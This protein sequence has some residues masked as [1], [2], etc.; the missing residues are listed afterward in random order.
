M[1]SK[2]A[3]V[4]LLLA[5][6]CLVLG[7]WR[8]WLSPLERIARQAGPPP[9]KVLIV[10]IDGATFRIAD[11]LLAAGRLPVLQGLIARGVRAELRSEK[12][13]MS[14][15]LWTTVITGQERRDHGIHG[16]VVR[17]RADQEGG[18]LVGSRDRKVLA[19]WNIASALSRR[20]GFLGWWASWPAEPVRGFV[21]S[22]RMTEDRWNL[23]TGG[24][25][26]TGLVYPETLAAEVAPLVVRPDELPMGEILELAELTP[27]EQAELQAARRP[28][29]GHALSVLKFAFCSQRSLEKMAL[30]LLPRDQPDLAGLFLVASDPISHT[31]WHYY[32]PAA[33]EGVDPAAAARLGRL[34]PGI[35]E[36]DDRFL[37]QLLARLDPRTA[38]LVVSDHGFKAS[39]KLPAPKPV[40][41]LFSGPEAEAAQAAE[42]VAV[43]QSGK[44]D[45]AG[46]LVAAGGPIRPGAVVSATLPDIAPTVLALLGLPVPADMEW[47][48]LEE[49]LEPAF[50]AAH[51]V[52][53][54]PSYEPLIDRT[55]LLA[56]AAP[57]ADGQ[58]EEKVELLRS[59]GYIR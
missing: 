54:I 31:V 36:H 37:G 27:S 14:P 41:G 11:P 12:P 51:P 23:W 29:F 6:S 24:R 46:M 57:E 49:M 42:Q 15:A 33:Y 25:R 59:L 56:A 16:F 1:R 3:A 52:R 40:E 2:G 50:L 8:P 13:M 4:L 43:G 58:G 44:H 26:A 19:L 9:A 5:A 17:D 38:V 35:Y 10:G 20:V 45:L 21:V 28:R 39:G 22:D 7:H 55:A 18:Q 48:V 34:V 53:R 30:H 47:R 32:E